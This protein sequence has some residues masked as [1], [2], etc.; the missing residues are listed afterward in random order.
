L[1]PGFLYA[2]EI[3]D[4][5]LLTDR[6]LTCLKTVNVRFCVASHA[7]MP[8]P[9]E[10]IEQMRRVLEPGP[11]I[12]RWSLHAGFKYADAKS[13]Y[14]PFNRLVDEDLESRASLAAACLAAVEANHPAFVII[15]NKAEGS[16]PLSIE[17]LAARIA[18]L[19]S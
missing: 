12:A 14:L 2:V 5:E 1:P 19:E 13:R 18:G 7:K 15:N 9:R 11:F 4:P 17:K 10:Q 8:S 3:R 6:F 16:A